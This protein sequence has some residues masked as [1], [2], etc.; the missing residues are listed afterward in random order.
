MEKSR[1]YAIGLLGFLGLA[2]VTAFVVG[3]LGRSSVFA[4]YT[5]QTAP[6]TQVDG[7]NAEQRL[8]DSFMSNFTSRLGVD[9][10]KLNSAFQ[11]AVNATADQA[12]R[13]GTTTQAQ[14]DDAK[15]MAQKGF[16]EFLKRGFSSS[17]QSHSAVG[18]QSMEA[19]PKGAIMAAMNTL[20]IPLNELQQGADSGKSMADVARAHNVN[21]Q[22][23]KSAILNAY[24]VQLDA[25]VKSGALT[26]AQADE[27]YQQFTQ[28]IDSIINGTG[29]TAVRVN[30][31]GSDPARKAAEQA[32]WNAA[33]TLLGLQAV[34]M[35]KALAGSGK[36]L[37]D[38]AREHNID[39]Q[40]VRA[41]MLQAGKAE[42]DKAVVAKT[43]TQAQAD[44]YYR[45]LTA[46]VD[47]LMN[48]GAK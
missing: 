32:A 46:W 28:I 31:S 11:G 10:A 30:K 4:A 37:S 14:V 13:D 40:K 44:D 17:S 23:L 1:K 29:Q 38:L 16:R 27:Q 15:N 33:P 21:V 8:M 9:E 43:L 39:P 35:K 45:G 47:T 25:A 34:D 20:G 6:A 48:Q 42:F 22:T 41:A 26:Q 36:S 2:L 7:N 3:M 12:V 18:Q 24:K 5:S 19:N